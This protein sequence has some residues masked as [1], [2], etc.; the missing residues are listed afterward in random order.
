MAL[1]AFV[2]AHL[3][4]PPARVLE[5]GCGRGD[6]ARALARAGHRVVAIDPHAPPGELFRTTTLEDFADPDPF[7]AVVASR[8]LHHVAD[9]PAALDKIARLL[10]L[11][12]RLILNEHAC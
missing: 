10:R 6:L 3:P 2:H 4:S 12:G 5:V 11:H 7:D 8:S 1:H 9:L